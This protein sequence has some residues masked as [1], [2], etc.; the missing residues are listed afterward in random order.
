VGGA[1]LGLQARAQLD[2][3]VAHQAASTAAAVQRA[4]RAGAD[5]GSGAAAQLQLG[6][7]RA[8]LASVLAPC[9]H[10]PP[11]LPR[12]LRLLRQVSCHV[13][14]HWLHAD[15]PCSRV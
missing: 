12:A 11:F 14:P 4:S 15:P 5:A 6:A 3:L 10:R 9:A 1:T 8:L 7:L 2:S 13:T